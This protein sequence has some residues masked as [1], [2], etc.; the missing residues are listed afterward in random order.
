MAKR[1]ARDIERSVKEIVAK[2]R[3]GR[4]AEPDWSAVAS[5][6]VGFS[7]SLYWIGRKMDPETLDI[8]EMDYQVMHHLGPRSPE[9]EK[10][11]NFMDWHESSFGMIYPT[12]VEAVATFLHAWRTWNLLGCPKT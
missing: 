8:I 7:V 1:F 10:H 5:I 4:F 6:A 2:F 3:E 9:N 12:Q 11:W